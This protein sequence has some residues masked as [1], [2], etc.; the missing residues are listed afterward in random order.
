[1]RVPS[2]IGGVVLLEFG[3]FLLLRRIVSIRV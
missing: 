1:M 2:L 3:G